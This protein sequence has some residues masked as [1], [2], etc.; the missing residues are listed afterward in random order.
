MQ[1]L[2]GRLCLWAVASHVI[3]EI[4]PRV[5]APQ[6]I[7]KAALRFT[8]STA[9][10]GRRGRLFAAI[11]ARRASPRGLRTPRASN[12]LQDLIPRIVE[13]IPAR[14]P[15][16]DQ[17][18]MVEVTTECHCRLQRATMYY[19]APLLFECEAPESTCLRYP[20]MEEGP[21]SPDG[22]RKHAVA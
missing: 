17:F 10:P 7:L 18:R 9:F 6:L 11:P 20:N 3:C 21:L 19:T 4:Q 22:R 2:E 13:E 8:S 12:S 16:P 1:R 14:L 15:R 5:M